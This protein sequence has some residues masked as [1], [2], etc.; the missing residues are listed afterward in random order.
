MSA[1]KLVL[2]ILQLLFSSG[3]AISKMI[4]V[5]RLDWGKDRKIPFLTSMR[6]C[7]KKTTYL[8]FKEVFEHVSN[9][10]KK[11]LTMLYGK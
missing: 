10:L 1:G 6:I 11:H 7:G 4:V 9:V 2:R 8:G 3:S 5:K